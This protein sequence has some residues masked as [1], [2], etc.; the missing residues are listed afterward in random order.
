MKIVKTFI[1]T[2]LLIGSLAACNKPIPNKSMFE[3]GIEEL[4]NIQVNE[5]FEI[6]GYIINK[7]K[8]SW[9]ISHGA[10]M[11]TYEI[12][13]DVGNHIFQQDGI[14]FTNDIGYLIKLK[15]GEMYRN[16]GEEHRSKKFYEF[17]INKAG[18]YK[19]RTTVKFGVKNEK[20]DPR[21]EIVSSFYEFA[22]K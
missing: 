12:L 5:S 11:F 7:S 3:A 9:Q 20:T 17:T 18:N 15:S 22:V 16:N 10:G 2:I 19:V 4:N 1:I 8:N 13:D 6:N 14:L 21:Q